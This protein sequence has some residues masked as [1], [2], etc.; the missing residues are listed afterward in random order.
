MRLVQNYLQKSINDILA[1]CY[2][3]HSERFSKLVTLPTANLLATQGWS[4]LSIK[5]VAVFHSFGFLSV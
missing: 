4:G 5:L 3:Q 1:D 2:D